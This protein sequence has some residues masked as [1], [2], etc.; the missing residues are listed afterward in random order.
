MTSPRYRIGNLLYWAITLFAILLVGLIIYPSRNDEKGIIGAIVIAL[1]A[2]GLVW[3]MAG[4][5]RR[6]LCGQRR[7]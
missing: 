7:Y 5:V 4:A 1:V 2:G 3:S 6:L